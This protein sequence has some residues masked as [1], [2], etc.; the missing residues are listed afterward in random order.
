MSKPTN[1]KPKLKEQEIA[2]FV[3]VNYLIPRYTNNL[4]IPL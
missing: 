4:A 1:K 2:K 3:G